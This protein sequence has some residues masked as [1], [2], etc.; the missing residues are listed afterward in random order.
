VGKE[1]AYSSNISQL[2]RILRKDGFPKAKSEDVKKFL[3]S[4]PSYT[5]HKRIRKLSFPRR[6]IRIPA[7]AIRLD[8]DLI[9]LGDL[10]SWNDGYNYIFIVI[11]TFSKYVWTR[12]LKTKQSDKVAEALMDMKDLSSILLYTDAGKE[13][14]GSPFQSALKRKHIKHRICHNNDFH[15]PFVERVIRTVKEKLFQAMT[16]RRTRRWIGLLPGIV[17]TYNNSIHSTV[18][19]KPVEAHD[20]K[21]NLHVY[22]NTLARY[23]LKHVGGHKPPKYK[24]KRGDL[25]RIYKSQDSLRRKGYLPR[26]TWEIFRVRKIANDR[27]L[28]TFAVPAY[29][30]EDLHGE[31]I[32]NALF[33]EDEMSMVDPS[34]LTNPYPVREIIE[35][36]RDTKGVD[37]VKVWW[38]GGQKKDAEWIERKKLV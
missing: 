24:F 5:V 26:F 2:L 13:F 8:G 32:E 10:S 21:N 29:V 37:W 25:V 18:K 28:D 19:M 4:D 38:Q 31:V 20:D 35:Q 27:S 9:E 16:S 12:P 22:K 33:Y 17:E 6:H 14:T 7:R 34:Q 11:D 30:L 23:P 36:K 3:T 15:C 1:G